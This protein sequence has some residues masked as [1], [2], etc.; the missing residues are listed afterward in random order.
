M[1]ELRFEWDPKKNRENLRRHKVSFEEAETV[2]VDEHG[3][4]MDD[5]D[6]SED[7]G[8]FILLGLSATLRLL[9]VCHTYREE[10]E[11]IRLISA[12]KAERSERAQYSRRWRQ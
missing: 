11:V 3:R 6:H 7:E 4:L 8:R 10:D 5:P 9:V 2:F 12:R 1:A